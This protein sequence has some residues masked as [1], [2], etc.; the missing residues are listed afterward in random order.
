MPLR[1]NRPSQ[2]LDDSQI[3]NKMMRHPKREKQKAQ[4]PE[5][6]QL[7]AFANTNTA[8]AKNCVRRYYTG[9]RTQRVAWLAEEAWS[10]MRQWQCPVRIQK[11]N[12]TLLG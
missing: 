4:S 5:E 9:P 6:N 3:P 10:A 12:Q 1:R 11:N 8:H 2:L 7:P